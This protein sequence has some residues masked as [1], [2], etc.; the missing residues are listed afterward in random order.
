MMRQRLAEATRAAHEALHLHPLLSK[1]TAPAITLA[2]YLACLEVNRCF[3]REI[4]RSR[5]DCD[6]HPQLSLAQ[7]CDALDA[8]LRTHEPCRFRAELRSLDLAELLGALYVAHG[9]RFGRSMI[10]RM[11]QGL[12]QERPM[13]FFG[14]R[15]QPDQWRDLLTR[16]DDAADQPGAE[17]RMIAGAETAFVFMADLADEAE[18]VAHP[19]V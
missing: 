7:E 11:L 12:P 14:Q 17:R 1:L 19:A 4:E 9:A 13:A 8:D 10:A 5:R 18:T 6:A 3:Y 2:E 15:S 16:L